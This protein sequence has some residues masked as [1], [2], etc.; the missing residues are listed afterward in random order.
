MKLELYSLLKQEEIYWKQRSRITWLKEGDSNTKYF[1][2]M[3]NGKRNKNY[4]PRILHNG[5]WTERNQE[6]GKIFTDHFQLLLGSP[7][8]YRFLLDWQ[9]LFVYN[10]RLDLSSLEWPFTLEE[11]KQAVFE[12]GADKAPGPDGFP[13]FFFQKH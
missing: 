7:R 13:M 4:I 2:L 6:L 9:N 1:H 5:L 3:A 11:I 8:P 12:L 10:E